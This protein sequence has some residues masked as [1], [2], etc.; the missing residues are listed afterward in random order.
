MT[1]D[2]DVPDLFVDS[3]VFAASLFLKKIGIVNLQSVTFEGLVTVEHLSLLLK[4]PEMFTVFEYASK[5][6]KKR[7]VP[8]YPALVYTCKVI[9]FQGYTVLRFIAEEKYSEYLVTLDSEQ[10]SEAFLSK[11]IL[12]L[13]ENETD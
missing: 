4:L 1:F 2:E 11:E 3:F 5:G 12:E 8:H 10:D 9:L 6:N 13:V 7:D